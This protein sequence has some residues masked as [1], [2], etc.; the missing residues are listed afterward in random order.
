MC[1]Y[2]PYVSKSNDWWLIWF[3]LLYLGEW[4]GKIGALSIFGR[5]A[6]YRV[7]IDRILRPQ[8]FGQA[9]FCKHGLEADD[10]N[11]VVGRKF[12][13]LW[14][15]I[16]IYN[17]LS[18]KHY[19]Q[20]KIKWIVSWLQAKGDRGQIPLFKVF[21]VCYLPQIFILT[22]AQ[23]RSRYQHQQGQITI[24][25]IVKTCERRAM[26]VAGSWSANNLKYLK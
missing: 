25:Q 26:R 1:P 12:M 5:V 23:P 21:F 14:F 18:V 16:S 10:W 9:Q 22:L 8:T 24:F 7:F 6:A 2:C 13:R 3:S 11:E 15:S 4:C 19:Y 17:L 20:I